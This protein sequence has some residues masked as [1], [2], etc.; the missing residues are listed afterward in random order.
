MQTLSQNINTAQLKSTDDLKTLMRQV[1]KQAQQLGASDASVSV[2][3]DHGFSVEVRLG[4]VE[5]VEF[6]EDKSVGVTVYLGHRKGTASS[7]DTSASAIEQMVR[8]ACDIARVSAEDTCFGLA[9]RALVNNQ[10]PDL[11]L[12]HPWALQ[13]PGAI[14]MA[15][16]CERQALAFDKR[17]T[18][19]DGVSVSTY[20]FCHGYANTQG[21]EAAVKSS[22]HSLSCALIAKEHDGM[23]RDYNYTT[24]RHP[25]DLTALHELAKSTAERT[26]SRLGAKSLKT[27][28]IPVVFSSRVSSGLLSSFLNAISGSNLYR[29]NSFLLD[30]Q[31]SKIFPDFIHIKEQPHLL[32]GL[33]STPFDGEGVPTRNNVFVEAGILKQYALNSYSARRMGLKTTANCGGAFNLTLAPTTGEL[34][35]LLKQMDR[36]FLVTELMGHGVN[37]LTG[38]YSR[39]AT[40]FWVEDGEIQYPVEEVTLAGNLKTMFQGIV[41]VGADINPNIAMR[42]GSI[43]IDSMMLSGQ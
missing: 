9:D 29:K 40:G 5:T 27:Q 42:C 26:I 41:A 34:R 8:A 12:F 1:L 23:Q 19:S 28:K 35:D 31:H 22:R 24:A 15:I 20:Q 38:D 14:D 6:N 21:C 4:E 39:G 3:H 17:L 2:N 13:P 11:D 33:G 18:N 16:E 43:L 10:Y 30:A 36:G 37:I 7:T 25:D 32:R